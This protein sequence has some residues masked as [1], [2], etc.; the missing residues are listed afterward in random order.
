MTKRGFFGVG[1][2]HT[3]SEC[4]VGTLLRSAHAFGA[5]F[6]FTVGRR[7]TPQASDITAAWRHVPVYHYPALESLRANLPYGCPLVGVEL[8]GRATPLSRFCHMERAAYVLGAE[9]H[10]LNEA[11]RL[12]CHYLVQIEGSA[13]CLNVATAGSIVMYDRVAK[14]T[15]STTRGQPA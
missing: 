8:D 9:D 5:D 7:Y 3:K 13:L 15:K 4:N 12:A 10:G 2:W 14:Q 1:I 11:A 6:V